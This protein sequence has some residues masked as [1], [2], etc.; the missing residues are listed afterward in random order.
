MVSL[1]MMDTITRSNFKG[2]DYLFYIPTTLHHPG[3][4]NKQAES[5]G[6]NRSR[7]GE[8]MLRTGRLPHSLLGHPGPSC[9]F[10][11]QLHIFPQSCSLQDSVE[12]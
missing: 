4:P 5:G 9:E 1:A 7:D 8:G 10:T 2:K 3:R 11:F 12:Q 6:K